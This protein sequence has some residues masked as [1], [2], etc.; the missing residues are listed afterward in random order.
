LEHF[1]EPE[2]VCEEVQRREAISS[3]RFGLIRS[4]TRNVTGNHFGPDEFVQVFREFQFKLDERL[5]LIVNLFSFAVS[6]F[7]DVTYD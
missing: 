7:L 2:L 1:Q 5:V 6:M 3:D 4:V